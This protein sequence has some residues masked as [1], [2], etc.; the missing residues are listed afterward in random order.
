MV[1]QSEAETERT[2]TK[3]TDEHSQKTSNE[4]LIYTGNVHVQKDR[5]PLGSPR[6]E[7]GCKQKEERDAPSDVDTIESGLSSSCSHEGQHRDK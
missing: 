5:L 6:Q 7:T 1:K 3:M 4:T 2:E